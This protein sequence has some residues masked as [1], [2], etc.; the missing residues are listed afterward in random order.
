MSLIRLW[1]AAAALLAGLSAC[2]QPSE[3]VSTPCSL[4]AYGVSLGTGDGIAFACH[5]RVHHRIYVSR[6]DGLAGC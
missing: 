3:S 1:L 6:R 4:A 2:R 5:D